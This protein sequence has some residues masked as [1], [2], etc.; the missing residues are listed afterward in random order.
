MEKIDKELLVR[1]GEYLQT[2]VAKGD[3]K[4]TTAHV[5]VSAVNTVM[6]NATGHR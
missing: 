5:Y 2:L 3:M 1:Y 6:D 4:P